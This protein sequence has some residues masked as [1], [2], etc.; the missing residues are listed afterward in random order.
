MGYKGRF[1]ADGLQRRQGVELLVRTPSTGGPASTPG[2]THIA[3]DGVGRIPTLFLCYHG[4]SAR[5]GV[6]LH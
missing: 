1:L 5:Y 6:R 4:D 3:P 2:S